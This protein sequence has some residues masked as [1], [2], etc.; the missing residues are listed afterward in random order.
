ME[1]PLCLQQPLQ[2]ASVHQ[3]GCLRRYLRDL[4]PGLNEFNMTCLANQKAQADVLPDVD[5]IKAIVREA[6]HSAGQS[7][8]LPLARAETS[9]S[10]DNS[11]IDD[12]MDQ[13][14]S[15]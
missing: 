13:E 14:Q 1:I 6:K 7:H 8:T 9:V 10:D 12:V 2:D 11:Y 5:Q 15:A 4:P 3:V